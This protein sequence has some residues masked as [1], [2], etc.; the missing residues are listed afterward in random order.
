VFLY[1]AATWANIFL[2]QMKPT[3]WIALKSFNLN[4]KIEV[5]FTHNVSEIRDGLASMYYP[6]FTEA[7]LFDALDQTITELG[8]VKGRKSILVLASGYDTFSKL[9]LN[10]ILNR[11]KESDVTIN[12]IGVGQFFMSRYSVDGGGVDYAQAENQLRTFASMA[13][14][15][16]WFPRFDADV[17]NIMNDVAASLRHQ[18]SLAY[19]PTNTKNDGKYRKIKVEAVNADGT[20]LDIKDQKGKKKNYRVY[21][22]QGY[23]APKGEIN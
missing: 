7:N 13:G 2:E 4:T 17:P 15:R 12:C 22:R 9:N 19:T 5:D 14:G 10:N 3:D 18:Y 16:A 11:L 21:A 8:S 20:P 1:S 6:P 23:L